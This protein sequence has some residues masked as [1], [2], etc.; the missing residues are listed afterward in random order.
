MISIEFC[1]KNTHKVYQSI[2]SLLMYIIIMPI[3][4]D[5][6]SLKLAINLVNNNNTLRTK[7]QNTHT[8]TLR[9][10]W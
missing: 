1:L 3:I 7:Q 9:Y 6:L 8:H 2:L 4:N 5:Y 10:N